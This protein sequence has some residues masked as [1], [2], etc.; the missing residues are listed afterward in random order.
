M[1]EMSKAVGMY[2]L[3]YV[4]T[5]IGS[6][7]HLSTDQMTQLTGDAMLIL[8]GLAGIGGTYLHHAAYLKEP[9]K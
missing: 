9:P 8:G 5:L 7:Y 3:T 2:T 1:L 6:R 4:L